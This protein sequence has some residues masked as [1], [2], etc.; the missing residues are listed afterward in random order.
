MDKYFIQLEKEVEVKGF[1]Q[2]GISKEIFEAWTLAEV[3]KG[4][5]EE[6]RNGELVKVINMTRMGFLPDNIAKCFVISGSHVKKWDELTAEQFA[7][8]TQNM[9]YIRG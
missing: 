8:H 1:K 3:W 7:L 5:E 9:F 2:G 4:F 6:K